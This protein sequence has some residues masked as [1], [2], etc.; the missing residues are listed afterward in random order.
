VTAEAT[1]RSA[2]VPGRTQTTDTLPPRTPDFGDAGGASARPLAARRILD[3]LGSGLWKS[4]SLV[5]LAGLWEALP[6]A[7]LIDRIWLPP[8]SQVLA[9][10]LKMLETGEL[11]RNFGS[12]VGRS[13]LG[14]GLAIILA[15]PLGLAIGWY[16]RVRSFLGPVLEFF[17]NTSALALLPVFILFLGI[18]EAS[19]VGIITFA[20]FFPILLSTIGGV[21]GVDPLL[22]KCARSLNLS[23]VQIFTKIVLP[24]AVP[25]IFTG[26]RLGAQ[27]SILVLIAAEMVGATSGLGHLIVY[28]QSNFLIAKMYAGILTIALLGLGINQALVAIEHRLSRWRPGALR[29]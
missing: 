20:C 26:F 7:G 6:R 18:G 17:R 2:R 19:K 3:T 22:I 23:T 11:Q 12:S 21:K 16:A 14:F 9:V 1:D 27:N 5:A 24:S 4:A 10:A 28:A 25:F 8:L 13:A 29:G 15:V